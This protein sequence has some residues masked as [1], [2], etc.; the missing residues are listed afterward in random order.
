MTL[1]AAVLMSLAIGIGVCGLLWW[2]NT[3][4]QSS[5]ADGAVSRVTNR[6]PLVL[7]AVA[8]GLLASVLMLYFFG[9]G[10]S[11]N[12]IN[13]GTSNPTEVTPEVNALAS[14][15]GLTRSADLGSQLAVPTLRTEP[16]GGDLDVMTARLEKRLKESTQ[17]D[18]SGWALLARSYVELG[19]DA[20]ALNAYE[21]TGPLLKSDPRIAAELAELKKH[22]SSASSA[23]PSATSSSSV[24]ATP[25]AI[26]S[27]TPL[28]S[29][30]INVDAAM[31]KKLPATGVVFVVARIPGQ[32]GAPLAAQRIALSQMPIAFALTDGD[33]MLPG[34][35]L[36]SAKTIEI[37]ARV[38]ATGEVTPQPGDL[39]S[40]KQSVE[41]GR[42]DVEIKL[43]SQR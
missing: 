23:S 18:H 36:S 27:N 20:D 6:T 38:S 16:K 2:M 41:S 31:M 19:R 17:D 5:V 10:K 35:K 8:I 32:A 22:V 7:I 1:V 42:R 34:Q 39:E 30:K 33:S 28:I 37:L 26:A 15:L 21:R 3:R 13:I 29:G 12:N 9:Q 24:T 14:A 4:G 11:G 43:S 25:N 40:I